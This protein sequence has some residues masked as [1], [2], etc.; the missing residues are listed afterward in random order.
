MNLGSCGQGMLLAG[1]CGSLQHAVLQAMQLP[2]TD[3]L[4]LWQKP[5]YSGAHSP[6]VK[7]YDCVWSAAS[8]K[9]EDR[10]SC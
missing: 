4:G 3:V 8:Y 7:L 9:T 1:V 2:V 6:N 10:V 5:P